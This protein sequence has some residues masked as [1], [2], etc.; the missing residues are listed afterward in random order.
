M[1]L[2]KLRAFIILNQK[3]G[4]LLL[5]WIDFKNAFKFNAE[6][7]NLLNDIANK[8]EFDDFKIQIFVKII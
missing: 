6:K 1:N 5:K 4:M 2:I 7:L 8:N 3:G